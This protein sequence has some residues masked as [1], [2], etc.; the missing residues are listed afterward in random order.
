MPLSQT[1]G[2]IVAG[3]DGAHT[4]GDA[5]APCEAL[6]Q[7]VVE[8]DEVIANPD[9][10]LTTEGRHRVRQILGYVAVELDVELDQDGGG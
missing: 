2:S 4:R 7:M 5:D 8:L 10:Y 6:R 9:R 1:A 3:V